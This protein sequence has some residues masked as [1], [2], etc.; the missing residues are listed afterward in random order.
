MELASVAVDAVEPEQHDAVVAVIERELDRDRIRIAV[1][2]AEVVEEDGVDVPPLGEAATVGVERVHLWSGPRREVVFVVTLLDE[3]DRDVRAGVGRAR[4]RLVVS[5]PASVLEL[6]CRDPAA[7]GEEPGADHA[8]RVEVVALVP[9]VVSE[10][11]PLVR[12]DEREQHAADL[13]RVIADAFGNERIRVL[14]RAPSAGGT[15][16][17]PWRTRRSPVRRS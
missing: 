7:A 10:L 15:R 14:H 4:D 3:V 12:V 16:L 1:R 9:A 8:A 2:G 13:D 6:A 17:R 5:G 11:V